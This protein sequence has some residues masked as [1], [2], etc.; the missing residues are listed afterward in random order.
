MGM[1]LPALR[2]PYV[3]L[4]GRRPRLLLFVDREDRNPRCDAHRLHTAPKSRPSAAIFPDKDLPRSP[5]PDVGARRL[6]ARSLS[7][8]KSV[9]RRISL[10]FLAHLCPR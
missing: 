2:S 5:P 6:V 7:D 4:L 1:G 3:H 8:K 9:H 10:L